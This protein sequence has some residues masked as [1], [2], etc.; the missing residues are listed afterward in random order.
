MADKPT[1]WYTR[2]A[3]VVVSIWVVTL[4]VSLGLFWLSGMPV[5]RSPELAGSLA[6]GVFV[7]FMFSLLSFMFY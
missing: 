2:P 6:G 1:K 7:A 4:S 3:F 5:E